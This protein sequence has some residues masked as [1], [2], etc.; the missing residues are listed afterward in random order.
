VNGRVYSGHFTL[1]GKYLGT[2]LIGWMGH[3]LCS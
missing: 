2:H 3:S 1:G